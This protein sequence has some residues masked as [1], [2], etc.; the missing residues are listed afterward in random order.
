MS[1]RDRELI[2]A[3]LWSIAQLAR[4]PLKTLEVIRGG[5]WS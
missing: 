4:H 3:V 2:V 1:A 5:N